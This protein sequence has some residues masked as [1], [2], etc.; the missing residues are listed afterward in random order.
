MRLQA[1]FTAAAAIVSVYA[2]S[3]V[4]DADPEIVVTAAFAETNHF[5]HVVN[6][7]GNKLIVNI[8]NKS[9]RN[10]TLDKIAGSFHHPE[11]NALVK[12][13]TSQSYN[14]PLMQSIKLALPYTFHSELKPG[15]LRLNVWLEHTTDGQKYRVPAYDSV[16]TVVEPE[17]S[18]FDLKMLATYLISLSFLGGIGY[19]VYS[20]LFPSRTVRPKSKKVENIS[21]PIGSV[22]ATGSGGYQEEWIPEHHLKKTKRTKSSGG[23]LTSGDES[24]IDS[25][26]EKKARTKK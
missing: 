18:I 16:V 13:T 26:A 6:G 24:G 14:L 9:G 17:R 25:G 8:E 23:G 7:E 10:V 12:N 5:G 1:F 4:F 2:T 22:L 3:A 19:A 20:T 15:D 21:E 11:S